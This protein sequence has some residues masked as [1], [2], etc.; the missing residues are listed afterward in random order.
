MKVTLDEGAYLP[1]RAHTYDAG[2]DLCAREDAWIGPFGGAK[3]FDTGVH[4][5]IPES[6][7]GEIRPRSGMMFNHLVVA[8]V[9]TVDPDYRGSIGVILFNHGSSAYHVKK[10]DRI[11]QL[12]VTPCALLQAEVVQKLED[13]ERGSGGFGSTGR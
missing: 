4:V 11:A 8:G 12:V 13:T 7:M 9:G 6:F 10:G 5:Q 2:L 3:I 1:V